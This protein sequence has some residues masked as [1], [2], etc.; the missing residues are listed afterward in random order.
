MSLGC[1]LLTDFAINVISYGYTP[2]FRR[3]PVTK[4]AGYEVAYPGAQAPTYELG[5][6]L[7]RDFRKS[8]RRAS[9]L[10]STP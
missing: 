6:A 7:H 2:L 4:I 10:E 9:T 3:E 5:R 1:L 8:R